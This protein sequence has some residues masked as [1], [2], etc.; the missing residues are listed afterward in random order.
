MW[1]G[2]EL[3]AGFLCS[4]DYIKTN[5]STKHSMLERLKSSPKLKKCMG[6]IRSRSES[7]GIEF[8][9]K[10]ETVVWLKYG[11]VGM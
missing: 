5:S 11:I 1:A 2:S 6:V 7:F 8:D 3:R 10:K 9:F 4:S